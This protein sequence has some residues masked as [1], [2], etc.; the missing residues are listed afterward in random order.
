MIQ[1][2]FGEDKGAPDKGA[3]FST[4]LGVYYDLIPACEVARLAGIEY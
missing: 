2:E 1:M 3:R 4:E